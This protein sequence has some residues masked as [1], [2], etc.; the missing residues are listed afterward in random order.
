MSQPD[1]NSD[2]IDALP[3]DQNS[4]SHTDIQIVDSLFKQKHSTIQKML[5]G[6]Q[7]I[8]IVGFIFL[9][10]SIPQSDELLKKVL[11]VTEKSPYILLGVKKLIFMFVY[12]VVKNMYLV[13]KK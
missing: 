9:L 2:N 11:P 13:R 7:D 5:A 4:P 12:F 1:N 3:V 10:F 6:T 8:L